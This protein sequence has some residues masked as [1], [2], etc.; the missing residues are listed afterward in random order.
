VYC[1]GGGGRSPQTEAEAEANPTTPR[2]LQVKAA[3]QELAEARK[4][5]TRLRKGALD[6]LT[7]LGVI[8]R[9]IAKFRKQ[10]AAMRTQLDQTARVDDMKALRSESADLRQQLEVQELENE[11]LQRLLSRQKEGIAA[12]GPSE[13]Q[14]KESTRLKLEVRELQRELR[15]EGKASLVN[16]RQQQQQHLEFAKLCE[17]RGRLKRSLDDGEAALSRV[18]PAAAPGEL[19]ARLEESEKGLKGARQQRKGQNKKFEVRVHDLRAELDR[20]KKM[21][22]RH[23][24]TILRC[25]SYACIANT[26]SLMTFV[27][28]VRFGL[29]LTITPLP[30]N[31]GRGGGL[32]LPCPYCSRIKGLT[33]LT[34]LPSTPF[35][36]A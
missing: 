20:L 13:A 15:E 4:A 8:D 9:Q 31:T 24:A 22:E 32:R 5:H 16:G 28:M 7:D 34:S 30:I 1:S 19:L 25:E 11:T 18:K 27:L 21:L 3:Q 12:N 36:A 17:R 10:N 35:Q 33:R 23:T 14:Q 6:D 26:P 2:V 29:K